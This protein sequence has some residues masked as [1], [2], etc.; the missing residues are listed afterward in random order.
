MADWPHAVSD[1]LTLPCWRCGNVPMFDWQVEGSVWAAVVPI[2]QRLNVMCLS[3][4]D[5]MAAELCPDWP[6]SLQ[7]VQFT[8]MGVTIG[9]WP[10]WIHY[11]PRRVRAGAESSLPKH[12]EGR[13]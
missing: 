11:Y 8:G 13:C 10:V 2:D 5:A 9:L 1:G 7:E 3:C 12:L 6:I 4:F